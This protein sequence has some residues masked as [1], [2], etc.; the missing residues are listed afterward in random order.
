VALLAGFAARSSEGSELLGAVMTNTM[1]PEQRAVKGDLDRV[2][3]QPDP[4]GLA[5]VAVADPVAGPG[6]AHRAVRIDDTQ[7]LSTLGGC[8]GFG[9]PIHLVVVIDEAGGARGSRPRPHCG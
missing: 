4:D 9:S 3:D 5:S 7:H 1:G 2:V 6:E 8:G